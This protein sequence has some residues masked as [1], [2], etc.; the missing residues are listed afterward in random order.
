NNPID[1]AHHGDNHA[2]QAPSKD[3]HGHAVTQKPNRDAHGRDIPPGRDH[4]GRIDRS[5]FRNNIHR[6]QDHWNNRDHKYHWNTWDGWRVCHHYDEFGFHWWGFYVGDIYFWTRYYNDAY[7]WYEPYW[8]RWAYMHDGQWWWNAPD[9][10][11]YVYIN[12]S[13]YRYNG[14]DGGVVVTPDPTTP[15]DVPPGDQTP[16]P[17]ATYSLDGTRSIQITGDAKDA[18]LYDLTVADPSSAEGQGKWLA[19]GVT[20]AAFVNAAD[21]SIAKIV[22]TAT[23]ESGAAE[24]LTFDRDGKSLDGAAPPASV[25]SAEDKIQAHQ[26][27]MKGS[28]AFSALQTGFSW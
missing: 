20:S 6:D 28:E 5:D 7:W 25:P 23:D 21:G 3:D 19:A 17:A 27:K 12:G 4:M 16:A 8:H 13:W 11:L 15:V 1:P 2:V 24:T 26:Q 18:Y 14:G 9:G 10:T 22:L